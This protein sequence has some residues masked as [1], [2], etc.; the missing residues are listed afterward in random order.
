MGKQNIVT[1]RTNASAILQAFSERTKTS[2]PS[3]E[4]KGN[5]QD[6]TKTSLGRY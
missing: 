4:K 2:D 6:C 3:E 5:Y 1:F